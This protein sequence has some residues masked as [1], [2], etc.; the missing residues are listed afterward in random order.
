MPLE[1]LNRAAQLAAAVAAVAAAC[2]AVFLILWRRAL[3]AARAAEARA[4]EAQKELS[5]V[6]AAPQQHEVRVERFDL[7]W[8]PTLTAYMMAQEIVAANAGL[9][10]C[11]ACVQPLT[12]KGQ[13]WVCPGCHK[14]YPE[15]LAD[16]QVTDSVIQEAV[17]RFLERRKGWKVS[18]RKAP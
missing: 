10:H 5:D 11:R 9:P 6:K 17:K 14:E 4:S 12:L 7:L 1:L 3:G 16:V 18:L 2:A 15:S 13:G 8:Y